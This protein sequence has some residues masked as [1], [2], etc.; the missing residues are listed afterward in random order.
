MHFDVLIQRGNVYDGRGDAA[1]RVDIGIVG[2]SI[3]AI[4][5]LEASSAKVVLDAD[6]LAVAPG[7][8]DTHTHSDVAAFQD[9]RHLALRA[10]SVLQGVTTAIS[11]NCGFSPFPFVPE[12]RADLE[13][14]SAVVFGQVRERWDGLT[15][16]R[17]AIERR[18]LL[19]NIAPL[20]GHGA[21]RAGIAGNGREIS[22]NDKE[23]MNAALATALADG[24]YGLST[25]LIYAPGMFADRDEL[26]DLARTAARAGRPY[27]SHIR[28]ESV[29]LFDALDEAL[30]IGRRSG[31]SVHISH[32]KAAGRDNW[33]RTSETLQRIDAA[34]SSGIDVW[35]DVYPYVYGSTLLSALLP[36][37]VHI[38]GVSSLVARLGDSSVRQ[39]IADELSEEAW[40][41]MARA[42]G[43]DG[44]LIASCPGD[45]DVEGRSIAEIADL[46]H[47]EAPDVVF[48]LLVAQRGAVMMN[49][50][51]MSEP[52]VRNVLRHPNS[53]IGSD[54]I[55]LP[56]KPHP[57]LAGTFARVLGR[58]V[59]EE[60]V[61]DL[62]V[63]IKKMTSM[64]AGRF[65]LRG[66]GELVVGASADVVVF[67]PATVLDLATFENPLA[68]PRGIRDVLL[69]G[70]VVVRNGLLTGTRPGEVLTP[71]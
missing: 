5:A 19:S 63:A 70:A 7:F 39:R 4:G 50:R 69:N 64:P 59:R 6:G 56:G 49:V 36:P 20:I 45:P 48:D 11:G 32:H 15:A 61:L 21:L 18:G 28:G 57:R 30:A 41:N 24:A 52:D 10:A 2:R 33:G 43:W 38:G 14:Q 12:H 68:P 65:S 1:Q 40:E 37:W 27:V 44:I 67:D 55:P 60:R 9:E 17:D 8:I 35:L 16:Y 42:A 26:I 3:T 66:R 25:G 13:S 34:R 51:L 53:M 22:P 47:R 29:S 58:Y 31:A 54:G 62:S 46:R 23:A 71:N